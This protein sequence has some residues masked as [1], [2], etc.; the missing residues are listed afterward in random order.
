M[1]SHRADRESHPDSAIELEPRG[2]TNTAGSSTA[3]LEAGAPVKNRPGH[4]G[5]RYVVSFFFSSY[6]VILAVA[7]VLIEDV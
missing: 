7:D 1:G 4:Q 6:L 3:T 5:S 2:T